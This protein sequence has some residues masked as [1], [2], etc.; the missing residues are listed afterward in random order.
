MKL[1]VALLSLVSVLASV[2]LSGQS[3]PSRGWSKRTPWGHPDLQGVWTN[4]TSTPFERPTT[5]EGKVQLSSA[6]RAAAARS[7]SF[8]PE[9]GQALDQ[10]SLIIEP[11]NGQLPP[12]TARGQAEKTHL[13]ATR[14]EDG[15][16]LPRSY[17]DF[18]AYDRCITRGLPGAM[19]PGFYNHNYQILQTPEYVVILVEMIHDV[20]IIPV[21]SRSH[22]SPP[23]RQWLGDSRGRWEGDTLVVETTNFREGAQERGMG[24]TIVGGSRDM[25]LVE[26]FTR[27]AA[28]TIDYRFTVTDPAIFTASWTASIPMRPLEGN[29]YEYACHEGNYSMMLMLNSARAADEQARRNAR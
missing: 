25:V 22:L 23:I 11:A 13:D 27:A 3:S 29:I 2:A 12:L 15:G 16:T 24:N 9:L 18:D 21:D 20:R 7:D 8:W 6:Q 10:T 26:R 19:M 14:V 28:D 1:R 5:V 4:T 17:E